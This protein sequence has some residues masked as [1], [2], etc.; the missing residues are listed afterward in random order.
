LGLKFDSSYLRQ[1]LS[2]ASNHP[3][4]I[5]HH[6]HK[7]D[8]TMAFEFGSGQKAPAEFAMES[9]V[10][11]NASPVTSPD[12]AFSA[13][14]R[15]ERTKELGSR[16][17]HLTQ[18]NQK[19][20][21]FRDQ[22]IKELEEEVERLGLMLVNNGGG[23]TADTTSEHLNKDQRKSEHQRRHPAD[24][25]LVNVRYHL[26]EIE[27]LKLQLT[28]AKHKMS[29]GN[30]I[31][32]EL[33]VARWDLKQKDKDLV[34]ADL[35]IVDR[36][37]A[38]TELEKKYDLLVKEVPKLQSQNAKWEEFS[39]TTMQERDES[40]A[41]VK[42][43]ERENEDLRVEYE[44]KLAAQDGE[45]EKLRKDKVKLK[46]NVEEND[47][48]SVATRAYIATTSEDI[49]GM[50]EQWRAED[51]LLIQQKDEE[52]EFLKE[53]AAE[54]TRLMAEETESRRDL[55]LDY[56][57]IMA[58]AN[59][60]RDETGRFNLDPA[61]Y[62][63]KALPATLGAELD[64]LS[65]QGSDDGEEVDE[66]EDI[67]AATRNGREY[68]E[69]ATQTEADYAEAMTQTQ[70]EYADVGIQ[71]EVDKTKHADAT[72][73]TD[74]VQ[75]GVI[76]VP[77]TLDT[78]IVY[79][80]VNN[81]RQSTI[82]HIAEVNV[83]AVK[84]FCHSIIAGIKNLNLPVNRFTLFDFGRGTLRDGLTKVQ[85]N[86]QPNIQDTEA[87]VVDCTSPPSS[88]TQ[89]SSLPQDMSL[90]HQLR[91]PLSHPKPAAYP[92]FVNLLIQFLVLYFFYGCYAVLREK[93]I[94]MAANNIT[95]KYVSDLYFARHGYGRV[96]AGSARR[97]RRAVLPV[98][99][100]VFKVETGGYAVPG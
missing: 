49:E 99:G 73:Q 98:L 71:T 82:R 40:S 59:A 81:S 34:E 89:V 85:N 25:N 33:R 7:A 24:E 3:I 32:E 6:N 100:W 39:K 60:L 90:L 50:K 97:L 37:N 10:L 21:A 76:I 88:G 28:E 52:I 45:I 29:S 15:D 18:T 47:K 58:Q 11:P 86:I 16:N 8:L 79:D 80:T 93:H 63:P 83:D 61:A 2:F 62:L 36:E 43:L 65:L 44:E 20:T 96:G 66:A 92:L 27:N 78:I 5:Y 35:Q 95:R 72:T 70:T 19:A 84:Y 48:K 30:D 57:N 4:D 9:T 75:P 91:H 23:S 26:E 74:D 54:L 64:G 56:N 17:E 14:A 13:N 67:E 77:G 42:K 94:W 38:Y 68:S 22:R 41:E 12:A 87:E 1:T 69:I 46:K 55:Q 31:A 51:Q 53:Q